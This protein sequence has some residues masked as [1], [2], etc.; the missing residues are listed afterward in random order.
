MIDCVRKWNH[1]CTGQAPSETA[2]HNP[3][4]SPNIVL[5]EFRFSA[6]VTYA[7]NDMLISI[8][9]EHLVD[10]IPLLIKRT[11]ILL[12]LS[13]EDSIL[14]LSQ[15]FICPQEWQVCEIDNV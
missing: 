14:K 15:L 9:I 1:S 2:R 7:L 8:I 12:H 3:A 5:L 6:G 13:Y 4:E 10:Q 11:P